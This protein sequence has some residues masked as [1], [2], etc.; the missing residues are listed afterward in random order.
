[1]IVGNDDAVDQDWTIGG[2]QVNL[3]RTT[4]GAE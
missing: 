1:M 3:W 4:G 2:R